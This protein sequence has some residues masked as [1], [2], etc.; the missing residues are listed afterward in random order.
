MTP[1]RGLTELEGC[2]LGVIGTRGP[3]TP[4]AVRREFLAS[5]TPY[6]SGSAGA[7]YP[8]IA[9]LR[10][11][12]LIRGSVSTGDA[13]G[14]TLYSL[15]AA[16]SRALSR[17]LSPPLSALVVGAPPDPIRTRIGFLGLLRP[18][19]RH[20]L[21]ADAIAKIRAQ[22]GVLAAALKKPQDPFDRLALRGSYLMMAARLSWLRGVAG[23]LDERV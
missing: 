7:I 17:W 18:A 13:R 6:W 11:R 14:R 1:A 2:V 23:A 9:R 3:C 21:L 4:Y 20:A 10:R 19:G 8:L 16:G 22:L 12:R 15:T 5:L